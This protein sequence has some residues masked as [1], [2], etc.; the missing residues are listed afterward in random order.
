MP[1]VAIALQLQVALRA[2][3]APLAAIVCPSCVDCGRCVGLRCLRQVDGGIVDALV[4]LIRNRYL[5]KHV[6][7]P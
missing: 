6:F 2:L 1:S 5:G 4:P 7:P 3:S